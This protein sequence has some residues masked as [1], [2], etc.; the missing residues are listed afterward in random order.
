MKEAGGGCWDVTVHYAKNPNSTEW[1]FDI[2]SGNVKATN[3]YETIASYDCVDNSSLNHRGVDYPDFKKG[4]GYNG[5]HFDGVDIEVAKM[6]I[7]INKKRKFSTLD[8][9]YLQLLMENAQTVND[10][11]FTL[12]WKGQDF[13]FVRG[14]LRYK[15]SRVKQD[16]DDNLDITYNLLY[17]RGTYVEDGI[18]VGASDP[19][20]K[21]GHQYLWI[22]QDEAVQGNFKVK[23]PIAVYIER[24]YKYS[25]FTALELND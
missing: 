9:T 25:D 6:E 23:V 7:S 19:I 2:G 15:G 8:P 17:Q 20:E 1:N 14:S 11:H 12:T 3:S 5:T 18:T 21:E 10:D 4:I 16:A 24:V 13:I 22:Y